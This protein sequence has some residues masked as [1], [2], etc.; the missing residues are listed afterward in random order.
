MSKTNRKLDGHC[1]KIINNVKDL[2]ELI[3]LEK[4]KEKKINKKLKYQKY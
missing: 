4:K 2:D 1:K 3:E